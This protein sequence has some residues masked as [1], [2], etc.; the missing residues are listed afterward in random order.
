[1]LS[2]GD[3]KPVQLEDR[4]FFVQHYR[5]FPQMHS[6]NTFTNMVCW[7][8]YANYRYAY[9]QDCVL[10]SSTIG[11]KTRYRPP[12]GPHNPD[13]LHE[14]M[15]LALRSDEERP[16]VVLDQGTLDWIKS[17]YPELKLDPE[18]M[19]FEY[20]YLASDL[21]LLP[22]KGYS[23]IRRQ[24]NQFMK[25]CSPKVEDLGADNIAEIN[26]FVEQWCEWKD[27]DSNPDLESE[28]EAL[29]FA[30]AHYEE[31]EL[32][33]IA[34]RAEGKIGA[35]SLFEGLNEDT[36]LV[37]FEKGLPDCKGIYRAINAETAKILAGGYTY[38]NRESDMGVEGIR[39][40]KMRYHPHH[41]VQVHMAR[42]EELERVL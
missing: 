39:E 28:K 23:T 3:F 32:S 19:Y 1:M 2:S 16:F 34:I 5:R 24:L 29:C 8:Y 40:A 14:V 31:L 10:L 18:R 20:V 26:D 9:V 6:D 22:G 42:Q 30:L 27:C 36:A 4:D 35:I 38:I 13:L 17:L 41:M 25:N 7:N 21:A 12:I 11:G 33:G 15:S 37:H